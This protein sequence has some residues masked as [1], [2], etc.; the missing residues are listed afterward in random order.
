MSLSLAQL[1]PSLSYYIVYL[2]K[3]ST[4]VGDVK[5]NYFLFQHLSFLG[6]FIEIDVCVLTLEI[7]VC[8]QVPGRFFATFY[9]LEDDQSVLQCSFCEYFNVY[10][11]YCVKVNFGP[12]KVCA[13]S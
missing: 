1:S 12:S 11:L 5:M 13:T 6:A 3:R 4:G 8:V 7:Y 10:K 9:Y 2:S